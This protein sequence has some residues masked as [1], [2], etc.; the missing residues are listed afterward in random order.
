MVIIR[1][2]VNFIRKLLII[3][4]FDLKS[5]CT[6]YHFLFVMNENFL[7]GEMSIDHLIA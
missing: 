4:V 6:L 5:L 1:T 3:I 2:I 7:T